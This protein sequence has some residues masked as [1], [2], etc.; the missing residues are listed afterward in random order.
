MAAQP[1]VTWNWP[2]MRATYSDRGGSKSLSI[3]GTGN[4]N[5]LWVLV[6]MLR[7]PVDLYDDN[8]VWIWGG[9]I[10]GVSVT[11]QGVT[12]GFDLSSMYNDVRVAYSYVAPGTNQ[13]GQRKTTAAATDVNSIATYGTKQLMDSASGLS[14]AAAT[15]RRNTTLAHLKYPQGVVSSGYGGDSVTVTCCGWWDT[16][17]WML[18][19]WGSLSAISYKVTAGSADQKMGD[20]AANTKLMQGIAVQKAINVLDV[21]IYG[22][23]IL[24]PADNLTLGIYA[25]DGSGN[26]TGSALASQV[27]AGGTLTTSNGWITFT[28]SSAVNLAVG[29]YAIQLSRSGANDGTNY[30]IWVVNAALGY[31]GGVFK[32]WGGASWAARG[33]DADALFIIDVDNNVDSVL[34]VYDLIKTYGQFISGIVLSPSTLA[35]QK[36]PSYRSGDNDAYTEIIKLMDVGGPNGLRLIVWVDENRLAIISEE[37]ADTTIGYY[38]GTGMAISDSN[39]TPLEP[40]WRFRA[41][42]SWAQSQNIIAQTAD[43]SHLL[44]ASQQYINGGTYSNGVF[45]PAFRGTVTP[46]SLWNF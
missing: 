46:G 8:G 20:V 18:A 29:Q 31:A 34:Q 9:C 40:S 2:G 26:P 41:V 12:T 30:Y 3:T 6:G 10:Y 22:R 13:V 17:S 21:Q 43:V 7:C 45:T 15:A 14:D 27:I 32:L 36:L 44:D 28:F 11:S 35:G 33:T 16:L 1:M 24:A 4:A 39:G 42:G 37:P 5:D 19:S 25:V 23:K 38:I